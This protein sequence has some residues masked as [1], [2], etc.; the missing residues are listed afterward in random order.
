LSPAF[1]GDW[2]SGGNFVVK[3]TLGVSGIGDRWTPYVIAV[4]PRGNIVWNGAEVEFERHGLEGKQHT[5]R[6]VGDG[7]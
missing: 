1:D 7:A 3:Y 6:D 2:Q 4:G 5:P